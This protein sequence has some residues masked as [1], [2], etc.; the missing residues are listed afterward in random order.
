MK[1]KQNANK[2][3]NDLGFEAEIEV[4]ISDIDFVIQGSYYVQNL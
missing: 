2:L 1:V 3:D 4:K